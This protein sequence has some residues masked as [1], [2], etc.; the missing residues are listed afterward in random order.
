[1]INFM[2]H[3]TIRDRFTSIEWFMQ[4]DKFKTNYLSIFIYLI[5]LLIFVLGYIFFCLNLLS[6][7]ILTRYTN[8]IQ[9]FV[10]IHVTLQKYGMS[11][12]YFLMISLFILLFLLR[13][14]NLMF[15]FYIDFI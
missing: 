4:K 15:F 10:I 14:I 1:M 13:F 3:Q 7:N 9:K 12:F 11:S 6:C 5:I 8:V 2:K